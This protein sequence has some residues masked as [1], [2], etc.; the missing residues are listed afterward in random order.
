[1]EL[2]SVAG[3]ITGIMI[4]ATRRFG[5]VVHDTRALI[6]ALLTSCFIA[7]YTIVDGMGGRLSMN[8]PAY[9]LWLTVLDGLPMAIYAIRVRSLQQVVALRSSW[10]ISL[11]GA[12]LSLSA[13]WMVVWAMTQAPIPLVSAIRETSIIIAALIGA[14][15]FKD[16][17]GR[18]RIIASLVIFASIVL[19]RWA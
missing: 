19:L 7:G 16:P 11:F 12:A 3:V 4:F 5:N 14:W 1:V 15:Y 18:R 6:S 17:A 9:M 8:V 10:R 13:Y 2:V